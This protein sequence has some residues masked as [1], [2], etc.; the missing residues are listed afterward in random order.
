M[1]RNPDN[2]FIIAEIGGNH[3]GD[4]EYALRLTD[5]AIDSGADAV[6]YQIYSPDG[7]VNKNLDK[8]RYEHFRK[9]TLS[10]N[11]YE[12]LAKRCLDN[13]VQFMSSIW[14][15][16]AIDYFDRYIQIHKIGSGDLTNYL[17]L[18]RLVKTEKPIILSTAMSSLSEI[19]ATVDFIHKENP[20]YELDG[21]LAILQCV[22]MYGAPSNTLANIN[23]IDTLQLQFPKKVI[24]YS[25]HTIGTLACEV[26]V[27]KGARVLEVH[28]TDDK[29]REFRD[30]HI[31]MDKNDIRSLKKKTK[32]IL[33]LIGKEEKVPIPDVETEERIREF[34][35]GCFL[36]QDYPAGT[37]IT[38]S[39]LDCLRPCVGIPAESVFSIIGKSL[40]RDVKA[41]QPLEFKYF[42]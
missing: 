40:T 32:S 18:K 31:S 39:M 15:E 42:E 33:E 35:R 20:K 9:F 13:R 29:N 27:S 17:L 36:K 3:E 7:L 21:M 37:L 22:A 34:R 6:K 23:V 1:L 14:Q 25:D 12:I 16:D 19:H 4:L 41:L 8:N 24:G 10:Y 11:E 28:F 2:V 5:L 26:A 30:H 38:E